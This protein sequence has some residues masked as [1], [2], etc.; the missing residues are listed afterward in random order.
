MLLL[1][2]AFC[3]FPVT[4]YYKEHILMHRRVMVITKARTHDIRLSFKLLHRLIYFGI[5]PL[6]TLTFIARRHLGILM[7]WASWYFRF[8]II[9][10]ETFRDYAWLARR[11]ALASLDYILG[12]EERC[13]LLFHTIDESKAGIGKCFYWRL[14]LSKP[15]VPVKSSTRQHDKNAFSHSHF[16]RR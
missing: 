16:L 9:T 8:I 15:P 12:R 6:I 14:L 5:P 3:H 11:Q 7:T 13:E 10:Y 4:L 1:T 2:T